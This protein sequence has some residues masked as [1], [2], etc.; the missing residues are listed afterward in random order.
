[1]ARIGP[2]ATE[3]NPVAFNRQQVTLGLQCY[4]LLL[5]LVDSASGLAPAFVTSDVQ[6]RCVLVVR[7]CRRLVKVDEM[8][9]PSR[10]RLRFELEGSPALERLTNFTAV[11]ESPRDARDRMITG[12]RHISRKM[13]P[14]SV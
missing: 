7:D 11:V 1:M 2:T 12:D 6:T 9:T 4:R 5:L 13:M 3:G 10:G 8:T 14:R